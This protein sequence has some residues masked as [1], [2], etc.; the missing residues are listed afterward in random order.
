M[1]CDDARSAVDPPAAD[2]VIGVHRVSVRYRVPL[3]R[4]LSLKE[5]AIRLLSGK[6]SHVVHDA[7]RE[8]SL[9]V[10]RGEIFG[11]V[12]RNGA[13]KSTL[14]RL[15]ARV[16]QPTTGRVWVR[17]R[18]SPLLDITGCFHPELSGRENIFL[19]GAVLGLSRVEIRRRLEG[20][21][22]FAEL[23]DYLDAPVRTYS[24]GMI[25]RLG[26]AIATDVDPDVLLID[27]VLAV[28]DEAFREKCFARF[29][30]FRDRGV[31]IVLVSHDL[32]AV[33]K[34]CHRVLWL[35]DGGLALIGEA[36]EVVAGFRARLS[37]GVP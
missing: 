9:Q 3:E 1:T 18:V 16:I 26:F 15:L 6:I 4:I 19:N 25:A 31:T 24:S 10:A 20:I 14:L 30:Q 2:A 5:Y 17:G 35:E 28:G 22:A 23:G 36:C 21:V 8:V 33:E 7:L 13:G 11:V 37:Q 29:R 32:F 34:L 27:E 12:G